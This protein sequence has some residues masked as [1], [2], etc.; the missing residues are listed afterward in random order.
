MGIKIPELLTD[1]LEGCT[2]V[3]HGS[4]ECETEDIGIEDISNIDFDKLNKFT[5]FGWG[6]YLTDNKQQAEQWAKNVS[7]R[8]NGKLGIP[9][10]SKIPK[11]VYK[12]KTV[13]WVPVLISY[14]F[15]FEKNK[16]QIKTFSSPDEEWLRFI[17]MN[18]KYEPEVDYEVCRHS[19][20][21]VYGYVADGHFREIGNH[22][23]KDFG[24][25][26]QEIKQKILNVF[27]AKGTNSY[28]QISLHSVEVVNR[29]LQDGEKQVIQD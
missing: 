23:K 7:K 1:D 22:F 25:L 20:E 15:N 5:D 19:Y 29:I 27:L 28:K 12:I 16:Y 24:D 26:T 6:F 9:S 4:F 8:K 13:E 18:R 2:T 21:I 14:P 17:F 10:S 3:Y 11:S